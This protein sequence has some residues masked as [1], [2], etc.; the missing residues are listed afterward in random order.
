MS[1]TH[2][3]NFFPL[4]KKFSTHITPNLNQPPDSLYS[5]RIRRAS[6]ETQLTFQNIKYLPSAMEGPK[7]H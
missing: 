2:E 1:E 5:A 7:S 3:I 6:S 4:G